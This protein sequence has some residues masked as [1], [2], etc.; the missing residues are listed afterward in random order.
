MI[1]DAA[2]RH[3]QDVTDW[4]D[5]AGTPYEIVEAIGRGGMGTVYLARDRDLEREVALKVVSL[6]EGDSAERLLRE[7]RILARLEHPGIVPVH[8]VGTLPDGRVFYAMKRVRGKRLDEVAKTAPLAERLRVFTRICEAVAFAH[9]HGVI[10]RDLK[11]E[12]VMV[13]SFGEVLV[14]D[15]GVAK[16]AASPR[17]DPHP[18]APSPTTPSPS[19]GEGEKNHVDGGV[20]AHGTILGTPG[21]MAPEQERG[22]VERIDERTDVW[23]LGAILGFL[24]AGEEAPRPLAAIRLRAMAAEP[25]ER[26]PKVEELTGDLSRYLAGLSVGAYRESLAESAARVFRRYRMPILL[27]LAYLVMRALLLILLGR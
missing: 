11:P 3:L 27:V 12:N 2:L 15:W 6:P 18:P 22:E 4:P 14:M 16:I 20:T 7:A 19:L 9:A 24:L 5:L 25:E 26:Y 21:Y 1:S 13:G 17:P 10:H 23:A 8:D